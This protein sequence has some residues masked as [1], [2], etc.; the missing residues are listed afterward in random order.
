MNRNIFKGQEATLAK[1]R[2]YRQL[3]MFYGEGFEAARGTK[4]KAHYAKL[5][6]ICE[7]AA[8]ELELLFLGEQADKVVDLRSINLTKAG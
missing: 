5:I 1:A 4:N 8:N 6:R 7:N 3:A 2:A